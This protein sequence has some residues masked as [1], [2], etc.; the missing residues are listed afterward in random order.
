MNAY[1]E[2]ETLKRARTGNL[3]AAHELFEANQP[4]IRKIASK[5]SHFDNA[6]ALEDL[7]QEGFFAIVDAVQTYDEERGSWQ[8]ALVWALKHRYNQVLPVRR[9][10]AKTVSLDAPTGEEGT[11]SDCLVDERAIIDGDLLREDF[12]H[13]VHRMIRARTDEATAQILMAHDIEGV[14]LNEVAEG[15]QLSYQAM[16]TKRRMALLNLSKYEDLRQLYQ[17]AY[18]IESLTYGRSAE[19]AAVLILSQTT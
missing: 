16:C 3:E 1:C 8:Q 18:D 15:L 12:R 6:I 7:I 19:E 5:F 9:R 10:R 17:D 2:S 4:L 11:L 13:T 14:P